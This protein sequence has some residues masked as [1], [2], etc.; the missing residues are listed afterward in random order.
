ML[1][2][3]LL[4]GLCLALSSGVDAK[5]RKK[6]GASKSGGGGANGPDPAAL[7]PFGE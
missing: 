4:L 3:V 7:L 6:G 2:K 1:Q 5:R